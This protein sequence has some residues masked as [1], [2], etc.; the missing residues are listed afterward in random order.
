MLRML[1]L[2]VLA[3]SALHGILIGVN[4]CTQKNYLLLIDFYSLNSAVII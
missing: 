2:Q 1:V 3:F 4:I